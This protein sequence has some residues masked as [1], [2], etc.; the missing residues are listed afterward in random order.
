[1]SVNLPNPCLSLRTVFISDLIGTTPMPPAM[2]TTSFDLISSTGNDVPK[3][4]LN[5]TKSPLL[6][7]WS[8]LVT[9][10]TALMQSSNSFVSPG[11][12]VMEIGASP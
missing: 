1:M 8:A 7:L 3:G 10:P 4:P 9:F 12:D 2:K 11:P 5:Q 6:S